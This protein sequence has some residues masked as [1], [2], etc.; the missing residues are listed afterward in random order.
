MTNEKLDM[1]E[2]RGLLKH[3]E[4]LYRHTDAEIQRECP[5]EKEKSAITAM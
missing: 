3:N 2:E 4:G 1:M 5:L